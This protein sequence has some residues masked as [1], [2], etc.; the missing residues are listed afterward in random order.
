MSGVPRGPGRRGLLL[1]GLLLILLPLAP[2]LGIAQGQ[3]S[4]VLQA[5]IEG[6]ITRSTVEFVQEVLE[7]GVEDGAEA[8]IF[9]LNTPGGGVAETELIVEMMLNSPL[10]IIGYV[11]PAGASADS[12]GTWILM[13]TDLAAMAPATTIGSLQPVIITA[14][15][16]EPVDD[17]KVI[18][19][20]VTKL[21]TA[22]AFH[23]R[24]E[25][26]ADA[27]VRE[28]LN[29][30]AS[31]ALRA[32]AIEIVADDV[33]DL[34]AQAD[35]VETHYKA[36]LLDVSLAEV[37]VEDPSLRLRALVI[38]TDPVIA[39]ILL[40]L[41][42][43][44]IIFGISTPGHGAEIFGT[45]AIVL[46]LIGLGFAVNLVAIFLLVLGVAL[47]IVEIA[48]PSFGA[49]GTGGIIAIV[50]GTLFLAPIRPPEVLITQEQQLLILLLLTVPTAVV[51]AFLLFALLKVLQARRA[52]P[53]H[54]QLVGGVAEVVDLLG[55]EAKGYVRYEGELW[56]ATAAEELQPEERVYILEREGSLLRVG[57]EP[58]ERAEDP[59]VRPNL[60]SRLLSA[61]RGREGPPRGP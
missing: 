41:G 4:L 8:V 40:L 13:A 14:E 38:I 57:R 32:G 33:D 23:G 20:I 52:K 59:E 10:P 18:N 47:L 17:E 2:G 25:S 34:L 45:I 58:P 9:R 16:F 19:N 54:D 15:G 29:L 5:D 61:L 28:N 35:G 26:L 21:R 56:R 44:G 1:V 22:L 37:R 36:V 12:A 11:T 3:T 31:D 49:V 51:G 43:Y 42:I 46:G 60:L 53:F 50:L 27:F 24:N 48:T 55:P 7:T 30:E 39:S 6:S